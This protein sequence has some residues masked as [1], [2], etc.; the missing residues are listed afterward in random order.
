MH[1][2]TRSLCDNYDVFRCFKDSVLK[3]LMHEYCNAPSEKPSLHGVGAGNGMKQ[4]F[5][6]SQEATNQKNVHLKIC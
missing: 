4:K 2:F 6:A 5:R 3:I 1:F